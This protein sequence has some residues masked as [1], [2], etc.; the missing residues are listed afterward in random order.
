MLDFALALSIS[1]D[2][3]SSSSPPPIVSLKGLPVE[4]RTWLWLLLCRIKRSIDATNKHRLLDHIETE[5][6]ESNNQKKR[7]CLGKLM[8][9]EGC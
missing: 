7:I 2:S 8:K 9:Y 4:F 3:L 6:K 1:S 5:E